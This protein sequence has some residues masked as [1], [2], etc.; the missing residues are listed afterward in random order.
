MDLNL[1]LALTIALFAIVLSGLFSGSEIA[2]VQSSKVRR[3]IDATSGGLINRILQ[4]FSRHEDMFIS[5]LLVGNNVVLVIYGIAFSAIVNPILE[6]WFDNQE[7]LVL[8]TNTICSTLLILITGEFLPKTTFRINP[9]LTMRIL[10]LPLYLIYLIFY[11]VSLFVSGLS[12]GLM[13]LFGIKSGAS[14]SQTLTIDELDDYI[15]QS[16]EENTG[17]VEV[18]NEVKI[19][20]KAIDFK[21]TQIVE[22]MTPR[23]EIVSVPLDGTTREDLKT[24]FIETGLSK[25]IIYKE[26]ID[27]VVGY[28]HISELFDAEADW[29]RQIKPVLFTPETMLANKMMRRMMG[30]KKSVTIV[31][32]EFGGTA[33][34]V[35]LEDIVEEIFGEIEDEHDRKR[36]VARTI[37]VNAWIFSGRAEI[38]TINE[39]FGL[40][41]RES[42]QYHTI[43]GY[44]LDNLEAL[45]TQ[46][47]TFRI[48]TL[49]FTVKKMSTTRIEMVKVERVGEEEEEK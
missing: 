39:D 43:A 22:C 5:T 20:R 33:G 9:N 15:Q 40:N 16:I 3:E 41:I 30:E 29:K 18:E 4:I 49:R 25:I 44:I 28:I 35:T 11:P 10:A 6:R 7:A 2:F 12:K 21:D 34:L 42:E 1:G 38:S 32:D 36:I 13:K 45:P 23:N 31:V 46:G 8:I 27:D 14:A 17:K 48:G 26:D 19:F 24:R 37:G 47:D